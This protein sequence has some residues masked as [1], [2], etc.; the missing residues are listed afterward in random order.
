MLLCGR[1]DDGA[2]GVSGVRIGLRR[3]E[4]DLGVAEQAVTEGEV[5]E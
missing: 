3:C 1:Q 4:H 5:R 2:Y